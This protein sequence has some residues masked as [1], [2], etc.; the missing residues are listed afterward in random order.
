[1]A[2]GPPLFGEAQPLFLL[3]SAGA[4]GANGEMCVL[5]LL[6]G[7]PGSKPCQS[8]ASDPSATQQQPWR[9]DNIELFMG[10]FSFPL[11]LH[12]TALIYRRTSALSPPRSS[13]RL[14]VGAETHRGVPAGTRP[15]HEFLGGGKR[16][17]GLLLLTG[18]E[19]YPRPFFSSCFFS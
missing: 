10:F 3:S 15:K 8:D 9:N 6:A 19:F 4:E 1:M 5:E 11:Q 18:C 16:D 12:G 17:P 14:S 2:F 13:G 7:Q